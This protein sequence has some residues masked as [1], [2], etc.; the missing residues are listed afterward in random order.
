MFLDIANV[1]EYSHGMIS[2][3]RIPEL[4]L[5]PPDWES[6]NW[7]WAYLIYQKY[8]RRLSSPRVARWDGYNRLETTSVIRVN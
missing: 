4:G 1:E 5:T 8:I 2:Q 7:M 3:F 6:A